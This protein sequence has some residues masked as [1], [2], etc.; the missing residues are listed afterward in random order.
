[1]FDKPINLGLRPCLVP[2]LTEFSYNHIIYS[3][4]KKL[5]SFLG[6]L[7]SAADYPSAF[8][9]A[10]KP[11]A[12]ED[13]SVLATKVFKCKFSALADIGRELNWKEGF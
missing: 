2:N 3:K 12:Q 1:M 10:T 5:L 8:M 11:A 6:T 13:C 4:K 7:S 9:F